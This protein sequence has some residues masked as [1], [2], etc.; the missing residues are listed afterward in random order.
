MRCWIALHLPWLILEI[1]RPVLPPDG[2]AGM[3]S[4]ALVVMDGEH[5]R[6][7]SAAARQ[8]GIVPGLRRAGV[9]ALLPDAIL[10]ERDAQREQQRLETVALALLRFSP[11]V[12]LAG[13]HVV[14]VEVSASLRLFGGLSALC[15]QV[16]QT[17]RLLGHAAR[18]AVA[19]TA[20]GAW[21]LARQS[22]S[23]QRRH[24]TDLAQLCALLDDL[25]VSLLGETAPH[26]GWLE[27]L[28]CARLADM[29][30]LPRAGLARRCGQALVD[31]L[32]RAYG[33]A[34]EMPA[35]FQAPLQFEAQL[36]LPAR[37]AQVETLLFGARRLLVQLAGWLAAHHQAVHAYE[38]VLEHEPLGRRTLPPTRVMVRLAE[39]GAAPA[40]LLNVLK[41]QLA[42]H[43]LE[44]PV[45]ELRLCVSQVVPHEPGNAS[46]LP[47]PGRARQEFVR[48]IERLNARL[49]EAQVS[50]LALHDEH[51][52]EAAYRLLPY[53]VSRPASATP[54]A[55]PGAIQAS[56]KVRPVWLLDSPRQ[57]TMLGERPVHGT[58]LRV[59]THA[60]RIESGWWDGA[61]ALRDYFIAADAQGA[62]LWVYRERQTSLGQAAW[63]L[64]GLFG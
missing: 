50:Q 3:T 36:A 6:M 51:R 23:R 9:L 45:L 25:P 55:A 53:V 7:A 19:P 62:L 27:Q 56:P 11:Q 38:L 40:H 28:G 12:V 33:D 18:L 41:E 20:T 1:F 46:L 15:R 31:E 8:A 57:L 16:G 48:L 35:W 39:P 30:R 52:P 63:Y 24:A 14:L 21:L 49:G 44:T 42:R 29:R 43:R 22:G 37:T 64:H 26:L 60:E 58:P 59:L 4:D 17:A 54:G 13:E 47:E 61:A 2:P 34:P 5:V 10:R 32:A